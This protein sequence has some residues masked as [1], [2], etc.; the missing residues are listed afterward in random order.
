MPKSDFTA[1]GKWQSGGNSF[2]IRYASQDIG[3]GWSFFYSTNGSNYTTTMG[4][5]ISDGQWHHIAVVRESDNMIT[6]YID[7]VLDFENN[8]TTPATTMM[9]NRNITGSKPPFKRKPYV[10]KIVPITP[11]EK[12]NIFSDAYFGRGAIRDTNGHVEK[13]A[14]P[15]WLNNHENMSFGEYLKQIN[16]PMPYGFRTN[17]C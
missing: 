8:V 7:G 14:I 2:A 12:R 4:S 1:L 13:K 11:G 10:K 15:S 5:D 6:T 9:R 3:T 17:W 16:Y